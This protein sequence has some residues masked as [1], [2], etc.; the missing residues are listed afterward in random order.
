MVIQTQDFDQILA[1]KNSQFYMVKLNTNLT[2]Y[3]NNSTKLEHVFNLIETIVFKE[4]VILTKLKHV[5][6]LLQTSEIIKPTKSRRS[7]FD[8]IFSEYDVNTIA[9]TANTN[10]ERLNKN[11]NT[12]SKFSNHLLHK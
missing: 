10:Y 1:L 7:I 12:I 8:Y 6:T 3:V 5:Q 4:N 9:R 2:Y 11:F